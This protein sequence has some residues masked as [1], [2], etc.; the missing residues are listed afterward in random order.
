MYQSATLKLTAWY[1]A[2]LM[3]ISLIFSFAIY[4]SNFHEVNVRLE[5][6]Q[7]GLFMSDATSTLPEAV[8][9]QLRIDQANQA[10]AQMILTLLYINLFILGAGGMGSYWLARKTL[11]PLE[12]SHEAQSRFTSDASHELRTPLAAMRTELEVALRDQELDPTESRELLESNL[13]EVNKLIALSEMLLKLARLDHD[14]LEK[15]QLNL[16]ELLNDTKKQF[17]GTAKRFDITAKKKK[18]VIYG[19]EPAVGELLHVLLDNALKYSPKNSRIA[20]RVFE[21]RMMT[22]IE[23][24]NESPPINPAQL[25]HLFDRFYRVDAS[26]TKNN[27]NGY[28]LGLAIAK[29]IVDIH[30]GDIDATAQ[31]GRFTV[32]VLLPTFR[33]LPTPTT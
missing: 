27:A 31:G 33:K 30:H 4:W 10:S 1:L 24:S 9:T 26:R 19:N 5:N 25:E 22:G 28:G 6:Y 17:T 32:I 14:K 29:R 16:L 15:K 2:V 11:E 12:Q 18:A 23:V 21:R 8:R 13:E 20:V 7:Q 3:G